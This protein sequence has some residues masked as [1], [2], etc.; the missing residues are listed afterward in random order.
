MNGRV[1]V[2]VHSDAVT[3]NKGACMIRVESETDFAAKTEEFKSFARL[4]AQLYY[5]CSEIL[6]ED[7]R[8]D[9]DH[10]DV[11]VK[12]YP[13]MEDNRKKV[14]QILGENITVTEYKFLKL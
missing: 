4:C 3:E 9:E 14:S 8:I 11:I 7:S 10:F 2:Y 6:N 5:A 13:E 1:E 12:E